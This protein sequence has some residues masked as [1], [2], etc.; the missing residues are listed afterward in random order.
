MLL[1]SPLSLLHFPP[2]LTPS[3]SRELSQDGDHPT[4]VVDH[5]QTQGKFQF[6]PSPS[7]ITSLE[8]KRVPPIKKRPESLFLS[9]SLRPSLSSSNAV[10]PLLSPAL[11]SGR[12]SSFYHHLSSRTTTPRDSPAIVTSELPTPTPAI[13][14]KLLPALPEAHALFLTLT[15]VHCLEPAEDMSYSP[16][17]FQI[18][19]G[20]SGVSATSG[21]CGLGFVED[22]QE[23]YSEVDQVEWMG[24]LGATQT[25]YAP[26]SGTKTPPSMLGKSQYVCAIGW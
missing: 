22:S 25:G 16:Y 5:C 7:L 8:D 9:P 17:Q 12:H 2:F 18:N 3:Y 4:T 11:R 1:L 24:N 19:G 26:I 6:P 15:L 21:K 10:T 13:N 23:A 14:N 20:S